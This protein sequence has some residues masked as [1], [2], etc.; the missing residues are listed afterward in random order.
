MLST[1]AAA[2]AASSASTS[3]SSLCLKEQCLLVETTKK[4]VTEA[5]IPLKTMTGDGVFAARILC[6]TSHRLS[7]VT[8]HTSHVTCSVWA[9]SENDDTNTDMLSPREAPA[10]PPPHF[11]PLNMS[12]ALAAGSAAASGNDAADDDQDELS[13]EYSMRN[14][15][16]NSLARKKSIAVRRT[17]RLWTCVMK[18][19]D[20]NYV[21]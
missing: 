5:E 9:E 6:H 4:L 7:H 15:H 2:A 18:C 21:R 11:K 13:F 16:A 8:C 17:L 19:L 12:K 20:M 1:S 3:R 10:L 14:S